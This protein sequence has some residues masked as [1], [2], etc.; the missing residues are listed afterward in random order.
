MDS[1]RKYIEDK[2][3][4]EIDEWFYE[5]LSY[6][7]IEDASLIIAQTLAVLESLP[8]KNGWS[9]EVAGVIKNE[10]PIFFVVEYLKQ[11]Q[12]IPILIDI[13]EIELDEYLDFISQLK[14]IKSYLN[15][16]SNRNFILKGRTLR[17]SDSRD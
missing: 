4:Y 2:V 7:K 14:T 5:Q 17:S 15:E 13:N 9:Q 3:E 10:E 6:Y 12:E 8:E 1:T 11:P 16:Q